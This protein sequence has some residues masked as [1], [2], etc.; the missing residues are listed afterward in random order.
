[1]ITT[2]D[3]FQLDITNKIWKNKNYYMYYKMHAIYYI[4]ESK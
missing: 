1:M 2:F 4:N 3:Q